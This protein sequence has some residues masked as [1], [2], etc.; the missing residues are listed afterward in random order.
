MKNLIRLLVI[1]NLFIA[2]MGVAFSSLIAAGFGLAG[3]ESP[4]VRVLLSVGWVASVIV[5]YTSILSAFFI[6]TATA[7]RTKR[8]V[9]TISAAAQEASGSSPAQVLPKGEWN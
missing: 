9:D 3:L 2:L 7:N 6:E 5:T 8:A 4:S 1:G